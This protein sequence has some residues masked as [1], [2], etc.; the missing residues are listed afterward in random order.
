VTTKNTH[1]LE[2]Q[3][4]TT[5]AGT[6]NNGVATLT[7]DLNSVSTG[8]ALRDQRLRDLFFQTSAFP[9]AVVQVNLPAGLPENL[10]V[11]AS[12][13]ADI[14]AE[15]DLHGVKVPL[16]TRVSVQRL[17]A[18]ELIVQNIDP[19]IVKASNHALAEG[20]EALRAAVGIASISE[21]APV[22]FTLV[23]DAR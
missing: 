9:R 4:F 14:T 18:T 12:Q 16:L 19:V 3:E 2:V 6:I 1:T 22:D 21:A 13:E 15:L 5:L 11:G 7:L 8:I 10:A 23:F 17:N 20:V